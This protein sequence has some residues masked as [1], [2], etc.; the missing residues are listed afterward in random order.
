MRKIYLGALLVAFVLL[1]YVEP[2]Y[3][4]NCGSLSDCFKQ[5]KTAAIAVAMTALLASLLLDFSPIG[6]A[7]GLLE[8]VIGK[9]ILTGD[10]LAW[11]QRLLNVV[12]A[13][14]GIGTVV[15]N[16]D[17]LVDIAKAVD[18]ANDATKA[19]DN[20]S[21]IAKAGKWFDEAGNIRWPPQRG[22]DG[23]IVKETLPP[24]TKIDRYG[25]KTGFF[26]APAGTPYSNRALPPGSSKRLYKYEVIEPIDVNSGK[27]L[28]WFGEK[29]GGTQYEFSKSIEN[30]LKD[31]S[32]RR[33]NK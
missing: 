29:G 16:A 22:F 11:W 17:E 14:K 31:G 1:I 12:P 32:I 33:I 2:S 10:K 23:T 30:L 25:S 28:A 19:V 8:A 18:K 5:S 13:G 3:A 15:K 9:D 4:D 6:Y 7:K 27:T 24:G 20:V 21:D 26:A